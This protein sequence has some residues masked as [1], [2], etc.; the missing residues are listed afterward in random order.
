M[1]RRRGQVGLIAITAIV[2][3]LVT[4]GVTYAVQNIL[5][6]RQPRGECQNS[7]F[8]GQSGRLPGCQHQLHCGA[9]WAH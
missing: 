8:R 4:V 7:R 2:T 3:I 1:F 9:L 5:A 6:T